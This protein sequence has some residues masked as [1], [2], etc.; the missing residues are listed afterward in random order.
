MNSILHSR[1][2]KTLVASLAAT[3]LLAATP[4]AHADEGSAHFSWSWN[5]GNRTHFGNT[6]TKGS[7][8]VKEETRAVANF[9]KLVLALPANVTLT[10]G[11]TESLTISADDNILPLMTTRVDGDELVIEGD[12]S[13]GFSTKNEIKIRLNVKSLSNISIRGSGDIIG[14]QLK[15]DKLEISI[16]GSGDVKITSVRADQFK[17]GIAGS[18]DVMIATLDSKLVDASIRGSGDIRLQSVQAG[19][20]NISVKGSGDVYAAGNADKVDVEI[21][22]SGDVRARKLIAREAGVKIVASGDAQVHANEKLTASVSGSGDIRY[23]GSP[24]SINR[25]VKGSG[26]IEA[27]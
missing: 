3:L 20:V 24:A 14:D 27:L 2:S 17:I 13:R 19:Q 11:G 8:V 5:F 1:F 22:G 12:R 10:Q 7:G 18:G 25:S 23:A 4:N 21:H 9:S 26:T 15:S 6:G 16:A